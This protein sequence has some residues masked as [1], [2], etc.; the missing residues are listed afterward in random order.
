MAEDVPVAEQGIATRDDRR[1]FGHPRG[2]ATLFLTEL[3]ERFSYYGLRALLILFMTASA[4]QGGL[5]FDT[6]KAG[7]VYGLYT[8]MVYLI[9]L[10]GGWIAD[11][12]IG[13]RRAVLYGGMFI[14]AGNYT[15]AVPGLTAFYLGL[16]LV[17]IGTGLLKPNVS[18]IVG[19][20][21]AP[22]D[23]RRDSGFSIFYMGIN[24]GAFLAPLACG[25][26]GQRVNWHY[27]FGLAGLGMTAGLVQYVLGWKHLGGAGAH[28]VAPPTP[29][30]GERQKRNFTLALVMAGALAALG[31]VLVSAGAV[32]AS[33]Q[34]VSEAFGF[35]LLLIVLAFFAWL[36][37]S[38][39]WTPV[40]RRRLAV[41]GVLF[42]AAT[43]FW[44]AFEQA[45]SSLNLFAQRS[46]RKEILG[47]TFPASWLQSMN[48]LFII[49]LAPVFAWLWMRLGPREPSSPGKFVWGLIGAGAGFVILIPA[50]AIAETG[51][52]VSV[53]WLTGTYLLHTI[54]ELCLSPVGL[55]A[56]TKLAPAR[57]GGL[58]MGVWFMSI[59]AG[60]YIG[61]R[62]ASLYEALPLPML[63][64]IVTAIC[65]LAA[66]VL[67]MFVRPTVRLMGG[68]R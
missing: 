14:A 65:F 22:E 3:W 52:Q 35:V 37:S 50:A 8:S 54:G 62:M 5:G 61:G 7:A 67:A 33:A 6:A 64:G 27:G 60:N 58:M 21:Y 28:P 19:Q 51:E 57:I 43:L 32:R 23:K 11:R 66:V 2:L 49:T 25:W 15:L 9:G 59:S 63:F 1:F 44:S 46:T 55:S 20:L 41:I 10:P 31:A 40:E 47:F 16:S 34:Q 30:A 24:L 29:E 36:Y 48:A 45:G 53:A 39:Q 68:L 56:M 18:A 12:I 13:Q 42:I 26:V 4:T 38:A 17:V